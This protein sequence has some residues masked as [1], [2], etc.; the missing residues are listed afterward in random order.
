M[1]GAG[2]SVERQWNVIQSAVLRCDFDEALAMLQRLELE[3]DGTE[4]LP[5]DR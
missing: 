2:A 1:K 5:H 4:G 3:L